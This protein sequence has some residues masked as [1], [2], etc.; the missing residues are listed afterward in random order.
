MPKC[1]TASIEEHRGDSA[2]IEDFTQRTHRKQRTCLR[3]LRCVDFAKFNA[4]F[5]LFKIKVGYLLIRLLTGISQIRLSEL[6]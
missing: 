3:Y 4:H 1:P 2:L 6:R 5:K